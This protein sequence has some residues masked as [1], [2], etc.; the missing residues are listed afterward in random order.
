M[1]AIAG[2]V[3]TTLILLIA[4][5]MF[6]VGCSRSSDSDDGSNSLR[7]VAIQLNWYPE[8]EHGG[9][10]QAQAEDRYRSAGLEVEIRPGGAN[11]PLAAEL[12]LGRAEFAIENA[13]DVVLQRRQGADVVAVA[14]VVQ[15]SPRC[16]LVQKSSEVTSLDDLAGMTLQRQAGRSFLQFMRNRGVLDDVKEVP[17]M[18]S[19]SSLVADPNIAIQAYLFSEPL[20]AQQAGVEV[21]VLMVSDLGWNPYSSVLVTTGEM[22]RNEPEMVQKFVDATLAGWRGYLKDPSPGNTA[23]LKANR[24]GMTSETLQYGVDKLRELAMPDAMKISDVGTM[25][26][27][28][29]QTLVRQ[30]DELQPDEAGNVQPSQCYTL[31]F[32]DNQAN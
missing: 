25:S 12:Q 27:D 28:R 3:P 14:A 6:V 1:K 9:V 17:Y 7:K 2:T 8:S 30:M 15:N 5:A 20:M 16:I 4:T 11:T 23:I 32:L 29:W 19:V 26:D 24:H 22:I 18:G 31:K 10:Y 21:N 13:D